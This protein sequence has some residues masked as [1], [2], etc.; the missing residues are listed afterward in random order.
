MTFS[1]TS[2]GSAFMQT[3]DV[4]KYQPGKSQLVF[5]T[6]NM[7]AQ[8]ANVLKFAGLSDGVN[9]IEF[10]NNGTTNQFV[11]YSST[12]NGNQTIT[13]AN[14]NL[15]KL[16]GTGKS[17]LTLDIT[18]CNI[19]CIDFQALYVGRVRVGFDI[20]GTII[21]CH[22]F[23]HANII[24]TPYIASANLPV[25]C[26]MTSTT[27]A[28]TTMRFICSSVISEGGQDQTNSYTFTTGATI[29]A[30][31]NSDTYCLTIRP[32]TTFNGIVNRSKISL[33]DI[34][35]GVTGANNVFWKLC[36]GQA[37]TTPTFTD[38]NTTYSSMQVDTT[39][40]LS[41]SPSVVIASGY[42][43]SN[44]FSTNAS[45]INKYPISLDRS[46]SVRSLGSLTLILQGQGGNSAVGTQISW[47][48][49][50]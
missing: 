7:I 39:G 50:R 18:K 19:L 13:Q 1:S 17:G 47:Q 15:D 28:T 27:S 10:Q 21:Y 5:V 46:G 9:G 30:A 11:I 6:F 2:S 23:L 43:S 44:K 36:I 48:E 22:E 33:L 20:G 3:F 37:L 8:V 40:T 16:N 38:V 14:W 25:R 49:D 41:G 35:F 34:D 42:A 12:S 24:T 26:G 45:L 32:K 31:N 4:F 29:T